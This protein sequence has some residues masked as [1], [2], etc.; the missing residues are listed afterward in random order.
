MIFAIGLV[1]AWACWL[2]TSPSG[3]SARSGRAGRAGRAGRKRLGFAR[4]G[5][6]ASSVRRASTDT[7]S[8]VVGLEEVWE[9]IALALEGGVPLERALGTVAGVVPAS[10]GEVLRGVGAAMAW[11]VPE[12]RIWQQAGPEWEP[13]RSALQVARRA[14]APPAQLLRAAAAE[15]RRDRAG[16][17]EVAAA[18]LPV[19]LVI[20]LGLLFLPAFMLTTVVPIVLALARDWL[21]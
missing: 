12:G 8:E 17:V 13:V 6:R 3:Q 15:R 1:L 14:G 9:L 20:P 7:R 2:W 18:R 4:Q 19:R 21:G 10:T 11:G 5:R 16:R